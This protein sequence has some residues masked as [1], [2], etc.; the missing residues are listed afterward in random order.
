MKTRCSG[1]WPS[2]LIGVFAIAV[3]GCAGADMGPG[4]AKTIGPNDLASLAGMWEG[5]MTLPSGQNVIGTVQL[6]ASG[7]YTANARAFSSAGTAQVKDGNLVLNATS[8]SG[9]GGAISGPR[10]ST[11][12][13]SQRAD[14]TMVLTG[15]GHSSAG[16][17]NFQVTK[18]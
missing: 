4:V 10:T 7:T 15:Y 9:G 11:A 14:G 3:F 12:S 8:T 13:L 17:F 16:P 6:S 2:F 18:K 5:S 1:V